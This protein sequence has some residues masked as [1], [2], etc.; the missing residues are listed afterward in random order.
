MDQISGRD[1]STGQWPQGHTF[2]RAAWRN[3]RNQNSELSR[4]ML[5]EDSAEPQQMQ[6]HR[7]VASSAL[8]LWGR[9]RERGRAQWG[10]E[11]QGRPEVSGRSEVP[12]TVA[13]AQ[14]WS[15]VHL[16]HLSYSG[17]IRGQSG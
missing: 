10:S 6:L 5:E 8:G 7:A 11:E 15:P 9:R 1:E 13:G 2:R 17:A 12:R 3:E 16:E 14:G 4:F